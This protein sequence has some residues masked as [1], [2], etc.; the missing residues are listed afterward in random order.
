VKVKLYTEGT[1]YFVAEHIVPPF[2]APPDVIQW[3]DR[4]F[5]RTNHMLDVEVD[6]FAYTEAFAYTIVPDWKVE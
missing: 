1:K 5:I 4:T 2:N 3:G 6:E